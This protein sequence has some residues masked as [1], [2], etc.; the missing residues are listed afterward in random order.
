MI[1]SLVCV[2]EKSTSTLL[3]KDM[4]TGYKIQDCLFFL[5]TVPFKGIASLSF[6]NCCQSCCYLCS[7]VHNMCK[8][9]WLFFWFPFL[10]LFWAIGLWCLVSFFF[11]FSCFLCL[12]SF[13]LLGSGDFIFFFNQ[14]LKNFGHFILKYFLIFPSFS[15]IIGTPA[16]WVIDCLKLS[17]SPLC[18]ILFYSPVIFFLCFILDN[19]CWYA[20]KFTSL[21][22]PCFCN[23]LSICCSFQV[24]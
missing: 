17:Q 18:C 11:F 13:E 1:N 15:S 21:Y 10:P 16:T 3:L 22:L 14:I 6:H 7:S 19:F 4:F 2:S 12:W 9:L 8:F 23:I 24:T 5:S 20:F